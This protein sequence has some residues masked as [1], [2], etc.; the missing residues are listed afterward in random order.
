MQLYLRFRPRSARPGQVRPI[1]Q[2][3]WG[4]D[5][6]RPRPDGLTSPTRPTASPDGAL[7]LLCGLLS[8]FGGA[9]GVFV[10]KCGVFVHYS[11]KSLQSA[12]AVA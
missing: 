7:N 2:I 6:S 11:G 9:A 3:R 12:T 5:S 10:E 4:R 1:S 8:L